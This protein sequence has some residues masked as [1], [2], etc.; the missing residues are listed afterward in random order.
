MKPKVV[1]N[2]FMSN[3][4]NMKKGKNKIDEAIEARRLA[5]YYTSA[6]VDVAR[7][8]FLIL[9]PDLRVLSANPMFYQIFK[10][11][12]RQTEN[13]F[14]YKLGNGQWNIPLLKKLLEEI[15]PKRKIVKNYEVQHKFQTIGGKTILLNA[16]QIDS[17]Q[18]IVLAMEDIT[19]RKKL[20]KKLADYTR[21]LE[22]KVNLRTEELVNQ[23]KELESV[24]KSMIGRELKMVEL[25][26]EIENLKKLVR[27][28]NGKNGNGGNENGNYKNNQQK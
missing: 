13:R 23:V 9:S 6:L 10:V 1:I 27:N 25:K 24:N 28:G 4:R 8:C 16:R 12:P 20:E 3:I 26:K 7:E 14:V 18:L 2:L 21:E 11:T 15:L 19:E 17:I 22:I 5:L